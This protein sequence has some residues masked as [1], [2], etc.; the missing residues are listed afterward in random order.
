VTRPIPIPTCERGFTLVEVMITLGVLSVGLL[1]LVGMQVISIRG[2][3]N[4][5]ETSLAV[6]LAS[7]ALDEL[8]LVD[9]STLQ[10]SSIP[11][12]PKTYDKQG[13]EVSTSGGNPYYTVTATFVIA[14]STYVDIT[15]KTS[16]TNELAPTKTRSVT[17]PGRIRLRGQVTP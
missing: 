11:G 13:T 5:A 15:I 2:A 7:S 9:Y 3:Q 12:F 1:G 10:S 17:V 14:G 8:T 6:N 4:A 16:W